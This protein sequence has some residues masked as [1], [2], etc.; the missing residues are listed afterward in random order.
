MGQNGPVVTLAPTKY[1]RNKSA[2]LSN[3]TGLWPGIG[4]IAGG[5]CRR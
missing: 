5:A 2:K 1:P 3:F 4:R